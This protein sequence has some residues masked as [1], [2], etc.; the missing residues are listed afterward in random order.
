MHLDVGHRRRRQILLERLP[1]LP[2]VE[3]HEHAELGARVEQSFARGI[4]AGDV[5]RMV[6]RDAVLAVGE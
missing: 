4:F 5:H 1:V 2:A 3:R 6:D